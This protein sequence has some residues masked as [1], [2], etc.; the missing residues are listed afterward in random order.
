MSRNAATKITA[1]SNATAQQIDTAGAIVYANF[2]GETN[3]E[4]LA[5]EW[6]TRGLPEGLLPGITSFR[7]ALHRAV[8]DVETRTTF[9][10]KH[11]NGWVVVDE[12][13]DEA[14]ASYEVACRVS[15]SAVNTPVV[16]PEDH[17]QAAK[18]R[19]RYFYHLSAMEAADTSAWIRGTLLPFADALRLRENGGVYFVPRDTIDVW[20]SMAGAVMASSSHRLFEIPA[21]ASDDALDAILD[22][23]I[24]EARAEADAIENDLHTGDLGARALRGRAQ[25]CGTMVVKVERYEELLG[26]KL[27]DVRD[28][29]ERLSAASVEAAL[30][31]E[32]EDDDACN[33]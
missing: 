33:V 31:W 22:A 6:N 16:E 21:L 20:R 3:V 19:E 14:G 2:T 5:S 12:T 17:A 24:V 23:V 8:R 1:V 18:I 26:R 11:A 29:L 15:L 28:H 10:R 25:R 4:K 9:K 7:T 27:D 32:M 13:K 30:V